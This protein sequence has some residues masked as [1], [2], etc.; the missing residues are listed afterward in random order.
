VTD[1]V[2]Y[3]YILIAWAL[4]ADIGMRNV[5][6][7]AAVVVVADV[8]VVALLPLLQLH[9]NQCPSAATIAGPPHS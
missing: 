7:V 4:D 1:V 9:R 5:V 2:D 6:A 3:Y 8:V